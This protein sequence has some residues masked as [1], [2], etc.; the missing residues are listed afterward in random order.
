MRFLG[1]TGGSGHRHRLSAPSIRHRLGTEL[2]EEEHP[3]RGTPSPLCLETQ[4][5]CPQPWAPTPA[6]TQ[7]PR[8]LASFLSH[9]FSLPSWAVAPP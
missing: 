7:S 9:S 8:L 2:R 3:S 5:C 6:G 4:V 1:G